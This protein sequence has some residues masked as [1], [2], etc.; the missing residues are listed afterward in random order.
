MS[1]CVNLKILIK[2]KVKSKS[3][4]RHT[5]KTEG[6]MMFNLWD[7][8]IVS[9]LLYPWIVLIDLYRMR[10]IFFTKVSLENFDYL[11]AMLVG[12]DVPLDWIFLLYSHCLLVLACMDVFFVLPILYS[13]GSLVKTIAKD[14]DAPLSSII[15]PSSGSV[16]HSSGF[17]HLIICWQKWEVLVKL[18]VIT[19]ID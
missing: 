9:K 13:M 4:T 16:W 12:C 15:S 6:W 17:F 7:N 18:F 3:Q 11:L 8:L 5:L 14:V 10:L 1:K 2:Q 19:T